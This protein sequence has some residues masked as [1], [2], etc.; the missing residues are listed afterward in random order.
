MSSHSI[1]ASTKTTYNRSTSDHKK[2]GA[3]ITASNAPV[4][5]PHP[6]RRQAL[7]NLMLLPTVLA[8]TNVV[9]SVPVASAEET[10]SE[11]TTTTSIS[12]ES[13]EPGFGKAKSQSGD[14]LLVH[15]VGTLQNGT[16][17]DSTR[18]GLAYRDGG[19]GVFRPNLVR[20]G[21]DPVPGLCPGL[22]EGL[23]GMSVGGKRTITVPASLGFG[24]TLDV[25]APYSIVPKSSTLKYEIELVR[26]SRV[27][28]DAIMKGVSDCGGGFVNQRSKGCANITAEEFL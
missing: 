4:Q 25:L 17:F 13:D 2:P 18:G 5:I 19:P 21:G 27:G 11:T 10:A 22:L 16:T 23:R 7:S 9:L 28:P 20:L 26:L 1:I 6:T 8:A 24:T 15:W 12:I 3:T 14:L